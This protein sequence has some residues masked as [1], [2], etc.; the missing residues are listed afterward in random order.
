MQQLQNNDLRQ[1]KWILA[2][3]LI[4]M[5]IITVWLVPVVLIPVLILGIA[6]LAVKLLFALSTTARIA[7]QD[8]WLD[9]SSLWRK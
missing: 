2:G 9:L 3:M 8:L 7:A 4:C 5:V 1:I 6:Y